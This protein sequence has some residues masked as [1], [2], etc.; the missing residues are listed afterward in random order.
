MGK[1]KEKEETPEN[2]GDLDD[3]DEA[4]DQALA[5]LSDANEKVSEMLETM[6]NPESIS[7]GAEVDEDGNIHEGEEEPEVVAE[8]ESETAAPEPSES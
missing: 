1:E 3:L 8:A 6:D 5:G 2:G 7:S 4:F